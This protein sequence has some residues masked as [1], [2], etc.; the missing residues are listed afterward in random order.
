MDNFSLQRFR[1]DSI[2]MITNINMQEQTFLRVIAIL[3]A[4][5]KF[6]ELGPIDQVMF[7]KS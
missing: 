2:S 6:T 7:I 4:L 1:Y 5:P 3:F